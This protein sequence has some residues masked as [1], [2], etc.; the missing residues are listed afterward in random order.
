[1]YMMGMYILP[2]GV[3]ASFDKELSRFFWQAANG[4]QKYHMVKWVDLCAPKNVGGIGI[5][6]SRRMNEALMLKWVWRILRDDGGL[7]LQ[8][9]KAKYLRGCP[10]MVCERKEGS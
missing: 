4:R 1:M 7:W 6:A 5:M 10:L 3:H 8:L 9:V 2:E